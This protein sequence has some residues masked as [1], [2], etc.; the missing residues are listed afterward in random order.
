VLDDEPGVLR[1]SDG[2][3]LRNER[4]VSVKT[5]SVVGSVTYTETG[6]F[7]LVSLT[8]TKRA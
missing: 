1:A 8:P 3:P 2:L 5:G 7:T 6:S 4:S